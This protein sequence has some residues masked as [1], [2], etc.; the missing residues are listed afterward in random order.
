[1]DTPNRPSQPSMQ[2]TPAMPDTRTDQPDLVGNDRHVSARKVADLA[3]R[4]AARAATGT[5]LASRC[6][7]ALAALAGH[8]SMAIPFKS[9]D[10]TPPNITTRLLILVG[11]AV[12]PLLAF[13]AFLVVYD[14][15]GNRTKQLQQFQATTHVMS[16]AIDAEVER[17]LAVAFTLRNA[18]ASKELDLLDFYNL[19]KAT[20]A[21]LPDVRIYLYGN[22]GRMLAT[23]ML[24]FGAEL[25]LATSPEI[26]QRV[27]ESKRPYVSDLVKGPD[28]KTYITQVFVPVI[29]DGEVT[30]VVTIG[31]PPSRISRVLRERSVSQDGIGIV[32]DRTGKVIARTRGEE[33]F[34]GQSVVPGLFAAANATDEGVCET[35][36]LEGI[37]IR[38]TFIKSR[39]SGWTTALEIPWHKVNAPLVRS[40]KLLGGGGAVLILG[41]MLITVHYGRSIARPL[42]QLSEMAVAIGRGKRLPYRR[43][44]IRETQEA[45]DR[46]R[47]SAEELLQRNASLRNQAIALDVANK[48]LEGFS[49]STSHVLRAPLRAIDGFSQ[50]LLE[51][52]STGLDSEGKRLVG[53]LRA[54]SLD[55][56]EQIDGI[57]EFLQLGRDTMSHDRIVMAE[58]VQM[59][60]KT[61]EAYPRNC[62]LTFEVSPL[63]DAFGDPAMIG[64]VWANVLDNALKFTVPRDNATITVGA[65]TDESETVYF[66]R[67][68][69]VGFDMRYVGKLFGVFNRLHGADFCGNGM[70]LAIVQRIVS[71]HGGRVWAEGKPDEGAT[72]YFS[73]PVAEQFHD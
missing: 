70:G 23:T 33:A 43:L 7:G 58:A 5:S 17:Q 60:L 26:I 55:I 59:A 52:H 42:I 48:E 18:L 36:T 6:L 44:N 64:R 12:L 2:R 67:D 65:V 16:L 61:L 19:A 31:Y 63:P 32:F 51:E 35:N 46:L 15:D 3:G 69:G 21:D 34:L 49:Y 73:L 11:V 62:Q 38:C 54:S 45:A 71:R 28:S 24:P 40:L 41:V 47:S 72:F 53:V 30:S 25:P 57:L 66:V 10:A 29:V 50:I 68:N 22:M 27:V 4:S 20:V 9:A 14:A 37:P 13:S 1:M 56:N 39:S 8:R